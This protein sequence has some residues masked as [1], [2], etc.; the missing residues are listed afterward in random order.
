MRIALGLLLFSWILM[1]TL[2]YLIRILRYELFADFNEDPL[3]LALGLLFIATWSSI[4]YT[5]SR[6]IERRALKGLREKS[7][8]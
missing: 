2:L 3:D 6:L 5:V 4:T 8:S 7:G 1:V